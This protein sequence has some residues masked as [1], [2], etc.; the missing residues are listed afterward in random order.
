MTRAEYLKQIFS[1][2]DMVTVLSNKNGAEI[3]RL[4]HKTRGIDIVVR[5]YPNTDFR[6]LKM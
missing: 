5:S 6:A 4:R 1:L 2:Y 3:L